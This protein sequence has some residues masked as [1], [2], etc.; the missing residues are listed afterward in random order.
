VKYIPFDGNITPK[1]ALI[2]TPYMGLHGH[3][4]FS[5]SLKDMQPGLR[6]TMKRCRLLKIL[7]VDILEQ[8][9][10]GEADKAP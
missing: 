2:N 5:T 8:R 1:R 7:G 4:Q 9:G 6:I 3:R 10:G